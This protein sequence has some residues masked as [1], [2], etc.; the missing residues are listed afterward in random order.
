MPRLGTNSRRPLISRHAAVRHGLRRGSSK[1]HLSHRPIPTTRRHARSSS[2]LVVSGLLHLHSRHGSHCSQ[3]T[4]NSLL[5]PRHFQ[6]LESG[7]GPSTPSRKSRTFAQEVCCSTPDLIDQDVP[8]ATSTADASQLRSEPSCTSCSQRT[9]D[10][11]HA[12]HIYGT[13]RS[14]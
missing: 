12:F 10:L 7:H 8:G 11:R 6:I 4:S 3:T 1:P 9:G 14:I 5:F 13:R 2:R